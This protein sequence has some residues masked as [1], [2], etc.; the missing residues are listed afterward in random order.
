MRYKSF[1]TRFKDEDGQAIVLVALAMSLFLFAAIGLAVD[2]SILYTHRQMAQAAADAAAQAGIMSI[3]DG[4]NGAGTAQFVATQGTSFT[5]TT[6]DAKT[7]CVYAR[8]N[9]FGG[10]AADTVTVSFPADTAAPGVTFSGSDST[11]L[12]KVSVSRNVNTTLMRFLGSTVTTMRA[13]AMAAIVSVVSPTPILITD[14]SNPNTLSMNGTT[15]ITICGGPSRSIEVNSS[16]SAAYGGGGTVDL[17]HAGTAD[18]GNCTTGTGADFGVFGGASTNP[19]SVSVGSTGHYL[20]KVSPVQDPLA[21]VTPP[22]T[23]GLPTGKTTSITTAGQDGCISGSCTEYWPGLYVGGI[24]SK[25]ETVIFKPGIYYMQGG[26]FNMK[27]SQGGAANNSVMCSG[28]AADPNTGTG[29]LIYD[30]GPAGSTTGN[31]PS[32]GFTIDTLVS[33]SFQG[34]T[35]TTHIANGQ[36]G[37]TTTGGCDVPTAPYY[38]ITFWE[39]RTADAKTHIIGKGNGC[40]TVIGTIYITN[41]LAIM[42][43][44]SAHFQKITYNGTPCSTTITQGDIITGQLG[45]VG[46]SHIKMNLVPQGF[47]NV[48]QV[49]LVN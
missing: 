1:V 33:A 30:T 28:C 16:N 4:T 9:G 17:S 12:I 43:G 7:P 2:G 10:S 36:N 26:G 3:F 5:C 24:K 15:G 40:F 47:L 42:Q 21:F 29:L 48:R 13:T 11:H 20:S 37:C 31:N 39:D 19:G 35:N 27:N 25:L 23:T 22:S 32:G 41:T 38:G 34:P 45:I 6:A 44:D 14:P 18:P 8:N 46:T 49:A